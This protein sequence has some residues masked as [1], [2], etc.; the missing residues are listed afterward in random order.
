[1]TLSQFKTHMSSG[2]F[3]RIL[4]ALL[5]VNIATIGILVFVTY[6]H[7]T[8]AVSKRTQ[9]SVR[10]QVSTLADKFKDEYRYALERSLRNLVSSQMLNDYLQGSEAEQLVLARR[11]EKEY[12][13]YLN[14][15]P[16]IQSISFIDDSQNI[17]IRVSEHTRQ[18]GQFVLPDLSGSDESGE[19][20]Q[21]SA[22]Y[23]KLKST[24][25]LLFSGNMEWFMPPR[26]PE[27]VGPFTNIRGDT[28][29]VIGQSKL[30]TNTGSFGGAIIVELAL[31]EWFEELKDVRF[32]NEA[33]IWL[34]DQDNTA[35]IIP[36]KASV[37]LDPRNLMQDQIAANIELHN[38]DKGLIAYTDLPLGSTN[39]FVRLVACMPKTLLHKDLDPVFEFLTI[40]LVGS[41][42]LLILISYVVSRYLAQPVA[43]L[44]TAQNRLANAQ[45]IARLGHWEWNLDAADLILSDTALVILGLDTDFPRLSR[46]RFVE[47]A[48]P[49]DRSA[50][51][52]VIQD[53]I[54]S[55]GKGSIEH[56]VCHS[57]GSEI[58]V[59]Q[60]IEVE[61]TPVTRIVGT[62]QDISQRK[63]TEQKIRKLAYYD[64]ITGLANRA[65]L[66]QVATEAIE[67]AKTEHY[68]VA[69]L[70]LDI[71]H[72]KRINDTF[73]HDA[74]DDLLRLVAN[75]LRESIRSQD[76]AVFLSDFDTTDK[77]V[78][79]LGGDEFVILLTHLARTEDVEIVA[80]RIGND[81]TR[82]FSINGKDIYT[83]GSIGISLYP[84]HA[85]SVDDLL[86]QADAAMYHAK[87]GGRNR[88][89]FFTREIEQN[90][91]HR[92]SIETRLHQAI[93]NQDFILH[94]Q[95]RVDIRTN[96]IVAVEALIR[97]LESN[98]GLIY[99]DQFIP[100]AEESGLIIPIGE[101]VLK[102]A[103]KQ[104]AVWRKET[105]TS[106]NMSVNLSPAQFRTANLLDTLKE[107]I[108]EFA[109]EPGGLELE[110]TENALFENIDAGVQ[111][112]Q[113]FKSLGIKLSIDD[114]GTGYSS[115][116]QL[117]RFPVDIIKI[118]KSFI[119]DILN[120]SDNALIVKSTITLGKNLGLRV[121]AEGVETKQQLAF[122]E[123][124]QCD[125]AQG[126][127]FGEPQDASAIQKL[128]LQDRWDNKGDNQFVNFPRS[129]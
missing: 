128:L 40:V 45:R 121:V 13:V 91:H 5:T 81:L 56:R 77:H 53:V 74:G 18:S 107:S 12:L 105:G 99:P 86:R 42:V 112:V 21:V 23:E 34:L 129:V 76:I 6:T 57:D 71:D 119:R 90:I 122:L 63:S 48:H 115:L 62:I 97:W 8:A 37:R 26:E 32:F 120:D 88:F 95:P 94:Y 79:R 93:E 58:S 123:K 113:Q 38:S 10:Q 22:L 19:W 73:G 28:V 1:M 83:S 9:E 125:E 54:K 104:L 24:P 124:H 109:F 103:C 66:N 44:Q 108:E 20:Y 61:T 110:L 51:S 43:A 39:R 47:C 69:F 4:A 36:E 87:N 101:W 7:N 126:Y 96:R 25:L 118:D 2:F 111:L 117:R 102:E 98:E 114:F 72:F 16:F 64:T 67:L 127:L 116:Q 29:A 33:T 52:K 92:L 41:I 106:I 14:D 27:V 85:D 68:R 17:A 59:Y 80:E 3:A 15:Y 65:L 84:D 60:D 75:R 78:A 70:F 50:L 30:E 55:H 11:L 35:F 46:N 82:K 49:E 89:E 100:V 31:D